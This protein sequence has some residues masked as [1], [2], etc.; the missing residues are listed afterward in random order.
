MEAKAGWRFASRRDAGYDLA[1]RVWARLW[2][3]P[4][5]KD[6]LVLGDSPGGLVVAATVAAAV[7]AE[8]D[9]VAVCPIAS[10]DRF[11][12]SIGAVTATGPPVLV[13]RSLEEAKLSAAARVS[14]VAVARQRARAHEV[15]LRGYV[16]PRLMAGRTIIVI[17]D[18]L[19]V[20][21]NALAAMRHV[22]RHRPARL[23][24]AAPVCARGFAR[25]LAAM[26]D[27]VISVVSPPGTAFAGAFYARLAPVSEDETRE[28]LSAKQAHAKRIGPRLHG[29]SRSPN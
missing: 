3:D 2:G 10:P 27:E 1:R 26:A 19:G 6:L 14:A 4:A 20:G 24:F 7:Q 15:A 5:R 11:A 16:P 22:R 25:A 17:D 9:L 29:R 13:R 18:G 12:H 28:L 21:A 8:L 23:I